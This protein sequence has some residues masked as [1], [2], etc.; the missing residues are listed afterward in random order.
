MKQKVFLGIVSTVT[1]TIIVGFIVSFVLTL[2]ADREARM[3]T[4]FPPFK[5]K[6]PDYWEVG[7]DENCIN[8]YGVGL[9]KTQGD[10]KMS[11]TDE[12]FSGKKG[13]YYKCA[14]AKQCQVPWEGID[15]LC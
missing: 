3:N 11:F 7:E 14:W 12:L 6:C 4:K 15:S 10:K 13:D 8:T 5:N 1:L 9:C 2:K